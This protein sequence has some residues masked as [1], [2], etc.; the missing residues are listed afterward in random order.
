[1]SAPVPISA[2][3]AARSGVVRVGQR[4]LTQCACGGVIVAC[5]DRRPNVLAAVER[6]N[7]T[8]RHY[9]WRALR[10]ATA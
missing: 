10:E 1:M 5:S 4:Y 9:E 7:R 8:G 2:L 6:H 3:L